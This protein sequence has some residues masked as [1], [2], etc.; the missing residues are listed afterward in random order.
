M[1]KP[2]SMV[3]ARVVL[4][5]NSQ[6]GLLTMLRGYFDDSGTHTTSDVVVMAGLFG[7]P[8]Q[9]DL[10]SEL[11]AKRLADPCPG[12]LALPRFH[13]TACQAGDEEFLGWKR[14]ECNF[15]VDELIEIIRK[16]GVYGFGCGLARKHYDAIITGD[17]RRAS[18]NAETMCII[19]C[20]VKLVRFTKD[21]MGSR[22]IAF[23][24]DDRP[25]Q[26][27]NV[28][29][30]YDVY[31]GVKENGV[32]IT[33]VSFGSSKKILPLQAADLLAWEVYQ[34][35]ID[36]LNGRREA[37]GPRRR[38]LRKLIERGR[39]RVEFCGP[40]NIPRLAQVPIDPEL[41]AQIANHVG[42]K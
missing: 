8:N 30:I 7:Y 2:L 33:S 41:L 19:N 32:D 38:E 10:F 17:H 34:D 15:L 9:W 6:D 31:Q 22:E 13:M 1:S 16:T 12:K 27:H 28:D 11:W 39:V 5:H 21:V 14:L 40:K 29:R 26:K 18:G 37:Q 36:S 20:F 25:Q 42:F 35:S 3:V 24:F 4:P 23:I